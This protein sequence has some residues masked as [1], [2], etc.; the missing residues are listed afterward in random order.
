M[1]ERG[2]GRGEREE[3]EGWKRGGRI[4]K[5]VRERRGIGIDTD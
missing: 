1:G 2:E 3:E 4:E 5:N